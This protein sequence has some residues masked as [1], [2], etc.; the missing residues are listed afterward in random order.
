M[1]KAQIYSKY[2]YARISPKKVVPVMNL[3]RGKTVAE[4]SRILEF[5]PTRAA[6]MML[7]VLKTAMADATNNKNM[8]EGNLFVDE[9]RV[10]SGPILK[11]GM[12]GGKS[13]F[14]PIWKRTSHIVVGLSEKEGKQHGSKN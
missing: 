13:R 7:K 8:K 9:I 3:V 1:E 12:I 2:K 10:D 5:D 14:K 11:R 4:A 6:K